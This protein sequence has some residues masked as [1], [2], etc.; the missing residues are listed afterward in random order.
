MVQNFDTS[1]NFILVPVPDPEDDGPIN[2]TPFDDILTGTSGIDAI[3]GLGGNDVIVAQ[4]GNDFLN[5]GSGNDR[6]NGDLGN[7]SLNGDSGNDTLNGGF[8]NDTLNGGSGNDTLNGGSGN[9]TYIV[10]STSDSINERFNEGFDIVRSS[11]TWTLGSDLERLD[12]TGLNNIGG[13]GNS[14]N[15]IINGNQG[16]NFIDGRSGNDT[17]NGGSGNDTL[18]GGSGSDYLDGGSGNDFLEGGYDESSPFS[19]TLIGGLGDDTLIGT[20]RF[21]ESFSADD[22][23]GERDILT[24]GSFNDSDLFVLGDGSSTR[25]YVYYRNEG[26]LDYALITDFDI[27]NFTGDVSDRIQLAGSSQDYQVTNVNIHGNSGAG[28]FWSA[29]NDL[30]AIVQGSGVSAS[31]LDLSDSNQFN[32]VGFSGPIF[33][34][35]PLA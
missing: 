16:R 29:T 32:Y 9:D 2:G 18:K 33:T 13:F 14:L 6:L 35:N 7:D 20:Q 23:L 27:Y 19:D 26:N 15:N 4:A 8:G 12:L 5:G 11:V 25:N 3:N 1:S 34:T 17:L 31:N 24:S 28:I 22:V 10:D 21:S 30:I